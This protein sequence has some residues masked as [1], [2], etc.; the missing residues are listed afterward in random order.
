MLGSFITQMCLEKVIYLHKIRLLK[1]SLVTKPLLK[2]PGVRYHIVRGTCV[3]GKQSPG[4][5][6]CDLLGEEVPL[7]K[8]LMFLKSPFIN[9]QI[10]VLCEERSTQ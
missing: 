4:P 6:H 8:N 3:F 10:N 2:L 9:M 1:L 7:K 5:G